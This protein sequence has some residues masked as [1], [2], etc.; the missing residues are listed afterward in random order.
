MPGKRR[1][2]HEPSD[3]LDYTGGSVQP[4]LHSKTLSQKQT[5]KQTKNQNRKKQHSGGRDWQIWDSH[6]QGRLH[7]ETLS[8]KTKNKK[9]KQKQASK[10]Q[11]KLQIGVDVAIK[12]KK[13]AHSIQTKF[14]KFNLNLTM[15]KS[16]DIHLLLTCC[17]T[18]SLDSSNDT[19]IKG[20]MGQAWW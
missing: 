20:K 19:I 14:L 12:K 13:S 5:N 4:E 17:Y 6:S 10:Q 15:K 11:Q 18:A 16:S 7:W 8:R 9:Q 3:N 2:C 1:G